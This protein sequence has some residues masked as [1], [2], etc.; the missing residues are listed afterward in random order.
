M[1]FSHTGQCVHDLERASAFYENVLGFE[2]V[3]ELDV[4][5]DP[6]ATLL[7]LPSPV[8]L[9]A[10]YLRLGDFVLELLLFSEP[11]SPAAV[12]RTMIEPGLTHNS[13]G[14]DDIDAT[15]KLVREYDG[16]VLGETRLPTAVMIK[17]PE[18]QLIELLAGS[19]FADRLRA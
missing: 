8:G 5:G 18:G 2:R 17:D 6:S 9:N 12:S 19:A 7:R 11:E 15:C 4:S 14:V 3:M 1:P 10:A 13:F 16:T